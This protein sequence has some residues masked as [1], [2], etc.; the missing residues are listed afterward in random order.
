[1]R[2][3][4]LQ[5]GVL[6]LAC[7]AVEIHAGPTNMCR[8]VDNLPFTSIPSAMA[9]LKNCDPAAAL[10]VCSKWT[11]LEFKPIQNLP[12]K[13]LGAWWAPV[14]QPSGLSIALQREIYSGLKSTMAQNA[15]ACSGGGKKSPLAQQFNMWDNGVNYGVGVRVQYGCCAQRGFGKPKDFVH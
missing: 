4:L 5:M 8:P 13:Y 7:I 10:Q 14:P 12:T 15:P 2:R 1:M 11:E 3:K 6:S 9:A